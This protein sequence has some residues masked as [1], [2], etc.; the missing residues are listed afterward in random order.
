MSELRKYPKTPY[1][2]DS[3]A[4]ARDGSYIGDRTPFVDAEVVVT[5]KL[6][7]TNTLIHMGDVYSRSVSSPSSG[8]WMGMVKKHHAWKVMDPD[9]LLYGEDIFGVHSIEYDAVAEDR[10]FYAFALRHRDGSFA[11][12]GALVA[13]ARELTIPVVPVLF[14]GEFETVGAV[15]DFIRKAQGEPSAL[16]GP[17]EGVVLRI[18]RGFSTAEFSRSVCK[19][20]RDDHV[21]SEEHWTRHWRPCRIL[22]ESASRRS[23]RSTA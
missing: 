14:E 23:R 6:D 18:A 22:D 10:T 1:W 19:S 17:R 21:Q 15:T 7:G 11:S 20:V 4:I 16:G 5:E 3:P 12:F 13:Y 9:I 2:P 8:K